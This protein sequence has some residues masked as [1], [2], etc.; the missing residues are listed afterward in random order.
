MIFSLIL[1]NLIPEVKQE[2]KNIIMLDMKK[3][4]EQKHGDLR[5]MSMN[6]RDIKHTTF[7]NRIHL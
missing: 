3:K 7:L 1:L 2:E 5:R 4:V 6:L